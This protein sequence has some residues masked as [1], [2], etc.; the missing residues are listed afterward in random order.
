M[1][2]LLITS[3]IL[4]TASALHL[5]PEK[6]ALQKHQSTIEYVQAL[7]NHGDIKSVPEINEFNQ[8]KKKQE[9]ATTN[10]SNTTNSSVATELISPTL[11]FPT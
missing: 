6:Q 11:D 9:N 2:R 1:K 4:G 3:C 8:I 7:V 5:N 10:P